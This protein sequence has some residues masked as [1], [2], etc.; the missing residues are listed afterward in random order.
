MAT[1]ITAINSRVY[2]VDLVEIELFGTRHLKYTFGEIISV[3]KQL[4]KNLE[5]MVKNHLPEEILLEALPVG[6]VEKDEM[7][8]PAALAEELTGPM[9]DYLWPKFLEAFFGQRALE[10]HQSIESARQTLI[11]NTLERL[12][13]TPAQHQS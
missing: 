1:T 10:N 11:K 4:G 3:K 12:T 8:T 9:F 6:L 7:V 5:E 13:G 2:P